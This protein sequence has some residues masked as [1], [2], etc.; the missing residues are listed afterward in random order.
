M[1]VAAIVVIAFALVFGGCAT[2]GSVAS[3]SPT[4]TSPPTTDACA[5][6]AVAYTGRVAGSFVTTI[7]AI[8][9]MALNVHDPNHWSGLAAD[10]A[11][12]LCYIDGQISK[13]PP[14][15]AFGTVPPSFDRVVAVVIDGQPDL[16]AAGYRDNVPL[17]AP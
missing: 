4:K 14:P 9:A 6:A 3:D 12:V 17:V 15:P 11:A 7:G 2:V 1:R 8:R 13:A 5:S 10:H 16:I